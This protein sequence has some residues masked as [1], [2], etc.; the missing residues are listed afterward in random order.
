MCVITHCLNSHSTERPLFEA[1]YHRLRSL[2]EA[3]VLSK[4]PTAELVSDEPEAD[5][6]GYITLDSSGAGSP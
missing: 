5:E 6:D 2:E 4:Q 1:L 3:A